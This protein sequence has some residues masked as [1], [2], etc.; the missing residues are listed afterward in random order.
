MLRDPFRREEP[1]VTSL[2]DDDFYKLTM[3][4]M[5]HADP[6]L[7]DAEV[8][9]SAKNRTTRVALAQHITD[10]QIREEMNHVTTL[11][12]DEAALG[13]IGSCSTDD[14][15]TSGNARRQMF[16][17]SFLDA[18]RTY[19]LAPYHVNREPNDTF[20]ITTRGSWFSTTLWEIHTL[21]ILSQLY[22]ESLIANLSVFERQ[23]VWAGAVGRLLEKIR[24]LKQYPDITIV[25]F[26]TRRRACHAWQR[27][28]VEVLLTELGPTQFLGTSN[29]LLSMEHRTEPKGTFAHE[30]VMG[31]SGIMHESNDAI[32]E[33]Q[34]TL[35]NRWF[36]HYG[37]PLSIALSDTY[38]TD[39]FLRSFGVERAHAWKGTRQDSGD[40]FVYGEKLISFYQSVGIDPRTKLIVFSDGLDVDTIVEL[41]ER[42]RGRIK[43]TFGWG[44]NLTNDFGKGFEPLSL[45]MKLMECNGHHTVKLSDNID[46]AMGRPTDIE[47]FKRIFEYQSAFHKQPRY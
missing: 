37:H 47:R 24:I 46:K 17:Q 34:N 38:G 16:E 1:I 3:L 30:L 7:R 15:K 31:M 14:P 33:S 12:F 40:P 10:D 20:T 27:Y 29:V 44:T 18:L 13:Y 28:V 22:F 36:A 5:I 19:R 35:F 4:G 41:A 39:F 9:F 2:I 8:V 43:V 25:D 21:Q 42:F 11:R 32:R 6:R 23:A 26:G 45:V